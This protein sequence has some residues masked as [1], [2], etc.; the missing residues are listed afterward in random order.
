M[1]KTDK[2]GTGKVTKGT[3]LVSNNNG[4]HANSSYSRPEGLQEID[5]CMSDPAVVAFASSYNKS[6]CLQVMRVIRA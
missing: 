1:V 3:Y 6:A 4:S 2:G 5:R